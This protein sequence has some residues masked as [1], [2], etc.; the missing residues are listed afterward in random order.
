M[1]DYGVGTVNCRLDV[2]LAIAVEQNIWSQNDK[3]C[4][5]EC[6]S[7]LLHENYYGLSFISLFT[8]SQNVLL[9]CLIVVRFVCM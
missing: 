5:C 6:F 4:D 3:N 8:I 7:E 9:N 1:H 2:C